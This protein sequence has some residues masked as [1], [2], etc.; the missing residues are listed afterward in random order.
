MPNPDLRLAYKNR[1]RILPL[2][3]RISM[4]EQTDRID[5]YHFHLSTHGNAEFARRAAKRCTKS[6]DAGSTTI[7]LKNGMGL[8]LTKPLTKV[9]PTCFGLIDRQI[10]SRVFFYWFTCFD[11][12]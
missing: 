2:S 7:D 8:A 6:V 3:H 12:L 5:H 1:G 11:F 4:D 10:F 9:L